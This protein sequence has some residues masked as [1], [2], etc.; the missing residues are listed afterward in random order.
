MDKLAIVIVNY[1]LEEDTIECIESLLHAGSSFSQIYLVDNA[2]TD[3]SLSGIISHFGS[4]LKI[5]RNN[6][7]RGYADGVNL[8]IRTALTQGTEWIL[9]INNDTTVESNFLKKLLEA[10]D[11]KKYKMFGPMICYSS[12]PDKIWFLTDRRL[13]GSLITIHPYLNR[14]ARAVSLDLLPTDF[15]HGCA[16]MIHHSIFQEIGFFD[17]SLFMYGEEFDFCLR[18]KAAGLQFA[19]VPA[20]KMWHKISASSGRQ[21][22]NTMYLRTR[23]QIA[24]YKRYSSGFHTGF[25]F[26]FTITRLTLMTFR[27]LL[28]GDWDL[29]KAVWQ[30]FMNGWFRK[31]S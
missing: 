22:V 4:E 20:A 24:I 9:A 16:M 14:P 3:S 8:G 2:S 31:C 6:I 29:V 11:D 7:N 17:T 30:G 19:A 25:L 13:F 1:N 21:P 28:R 12:Q 15:L 27:F 18:A 26:C 10:T 23:N 5:L